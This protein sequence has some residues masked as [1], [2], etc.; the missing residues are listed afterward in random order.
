[1]N[2]ANERMKLA[3]EALEQAQVL[4][5]QKQMSDKDFLES[6]ARSDSLADHPDA[7][8]EDGT[9][10][11]C[12]MNI[13]MA[14]TARKMIA[15]GDTGPGAMSRWADLN[16]KNWEAGKYFQFYTTEKEAGRDPY[17]SFEER[18]WEM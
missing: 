12:G 6:M 10:G 2:E 18:G 17:K 11:C 3:S 7:W 15:E 5:G 16:R 8:T 1:M 14:E 4:A 9:C 13:C